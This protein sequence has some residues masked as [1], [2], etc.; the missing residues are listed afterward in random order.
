MVNRDHQVREKRKADWLV[1]LEEL[2]SYEPF[3]AITFPVDN[4]ISA[5]LACYQSPPSVI[6]VDQ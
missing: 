4:A 2:D 1:S 3:L 5:S 6:I